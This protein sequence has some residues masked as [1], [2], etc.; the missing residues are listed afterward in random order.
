[1]RHY[2]IFGQAYGQGAYGNCEYGSSSTQC[3]TAAGNTNPPGASGGGLA[4]TGTNVIFFVSLACL[5]IF[6]G[7]L[8]RFWRRKRVPVVQEIEE[9]ED[10]RF[11]SRF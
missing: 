11:S 1:M 6:A 7:L 2:M 4:D 8:I 9:I 10:K 5:I 3:V